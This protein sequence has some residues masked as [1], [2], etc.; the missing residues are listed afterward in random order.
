M[1]KCPKC[2]STNTEY[3]DR[4]IYID[5]NGGSGIY[6]YVCLDCRCRYDHEGNYHFKIAPM[7]LMPDNILLWK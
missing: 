2:N 1:S 3:G 5:D 7:K 4:V 6:Y